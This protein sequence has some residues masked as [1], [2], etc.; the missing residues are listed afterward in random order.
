L[1]TSEAV[2]VDIEENAATRDKTIVIPPGA[3]PATAELYVSVSPSL[4]SSMLSALEDLA[5]YPYG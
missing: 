5:G 3:N 2:V 4:A 1:K